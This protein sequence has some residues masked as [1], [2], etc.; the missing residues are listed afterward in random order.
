MS[1][2]ALTVLMLL[3][4][5]PARSADL[6]SV[7][8]DR[9]DGAY[10]MRSEVLFEVGIEAIYETMLDWDLSTEFSSVVVESRN[11]EPDE[12]G[13]RGY[14]SRNEACVAF[15]C[16]SFERYG[17]VEHERYEFIEATVIPEKSDFHVSD[18]RWTFRE[19]DGG[20]IVT[21]DLTFKPKFFVPPLIGP[22]MLKRKLKSGSADAIDR[23]EAV[24]RRQFVNAR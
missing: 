21:Y 22:Y 7:E 3:A 18:E 23:I 9:V 24:A 6:L 20:T 10:T 4:A 2:L 14:Y 12:T 13:R 15:F 5:L 16:A 19:T 8:V 1:R 17:V 11:L